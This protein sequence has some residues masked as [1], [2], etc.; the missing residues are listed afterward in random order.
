MALYAVFSFAH[1]TC[2]ILCVH[3]SCLIFC[4]MEDPLGE[5][6]CNVEK[7]CKLVASMMV[8]QRVKLGSTTLRCMMQIPP[9]KM[10][11]TLLSYMLEAYELSSGKFIIE[12]RVGEISLT[13]VD[14]ECITGLNNTGLSASSILD[15]EGEVAKDRI[16][17]HFL[18][19]TTGNINIDDLIE[20]IMTN[21]AAD[22]DFVRMSVLVLVGTVLAPSATKIV[23]KQMYALVEDLGRINKINWNAFTLGYLMA[24]IKFVKKGRKIRQWPKGNLPLLQVHYGFPSH[25]ITKCIEIMN[26]NYTVFL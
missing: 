10:R 11:T 23:Q 6:A 20:Y 19:K 22:D 3:A 25:E 12:E 16:P 1:V 18:S 4:R 26:L 14:V 2:T 15:E 21:E 17:Q 9:I 7:W 5:I 13:S 8:D 24:N